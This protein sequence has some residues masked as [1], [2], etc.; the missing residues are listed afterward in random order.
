MYDQENWVWIDPETGHG[1][2]LHHMQSFTTPFEVML[3]KE[4]G[5]TSVNA[6]VIFSNHCFSKKYH[7]EQ[8][9]HRHIISKEIKKDGTEEERV[10]CPQRW[11]FSK[12]LPDI[13][14]GLCYKD[15]FQG[16]EKEII[17]RQEGKSGHG[18]H[19][20]W[21]ICMRLV[22]KRDRKCPLEIWVRSAHK[23]TNRPHD[24]RG[25][26]GKKFCMI[27]SDFLKTKGHKDKNPD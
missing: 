1:Y 8:D 5:K 21:Y 20:G 27:L 10:F 2:E 3:S 25:H 6:M 24:I 14:K 11:E 22:Y 4:T 9:D 18:Q 23:R 17:F 15:C 16:K 19:D 13:I 7:E 12:R 26:G